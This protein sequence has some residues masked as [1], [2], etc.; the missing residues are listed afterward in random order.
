MAVVSALISLAVSAINATGA[1][2]AIKYEWSI[3]GTPLAAGATEKVSLFSDAQN[4]TLVFTTTV[5]TSNV[6]L[7]GTGARSVNAIIEGGKPGK[8]HGK[9]ILTGLI[10]EK[11]GGGTKCQVKS[12]GASAGEVETGETESVI[13][14]GSGGTRLVLFQGKGTTV[15]TTLHFENKS[16][17]T[18]AINGAEANITGSVVVVQNTSDT[19]KSQLFEFKPPGTQSTSSTG[20]VSTNTLKLGTTTITLTGSISAEIVRLLAWGAL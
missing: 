16:P 12:T 8:G 7:R 1:S 13:V 15:L 20:T 2:A 14:E 17:E 5:L 11:P 9:L 6:E 10:V 19:E 4:P 3:N 18:C